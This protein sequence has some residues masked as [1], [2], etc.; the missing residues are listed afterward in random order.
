[1]VVRQAFRQ[2]RT[3]F[4]RVFINSGRI[5]GFWK[6]MIITPHGKHHILIARDI[7]HNTYAGT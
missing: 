4:K 7:L 2:L 1:M 5:T 6:I 3:D